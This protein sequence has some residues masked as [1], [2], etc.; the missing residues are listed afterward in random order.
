MLPASYCYGLGAYARLV[1]YTLGLASRRR[2]PAPVISVGNL[3][4]GGTGKT[5]FTIEL[6]ERISSAGK[7]VAV[8]SRGYGR[9]SS[10]EAVVVADGTGA[11]LVPVADS[12]DEPYLIA[13][14]VPDAVVIVGA[15]RLQSA[16]KA[17]VD[18]GAQVLILDDGFQHIKLRRDIDIVLWDYQDDPDGALLLP[19][20]RLREPLSGLNRATDIIVTKIPEDYDQAKLSALVARLSCLAPQ[21]NVASCRF[22]PAYLSGFAFDG[23]PSQ[24][25]K[26][27]ELVGKKVFALSSIARPQ[28]FIAALQGLG[29]NP[30]VEKHFP[31][32]HWFQPQELAQLEQDFLASGADL[33]VTTEKD[34]VRL[35]S[36]LSEPIAQRTWSLVLAAQWLSPVPDIVE[37]LQI[38]QGPL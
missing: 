30:V 38:A 4:V 9:K 13:Q 6:A 11:I 32:H 3:T 23:K 14:A 36:S 21:A 8:L 20:G 2:A 5:P 1:T 22:S 33:L 15:S 12:G 26:L 10:H 35:K 34:M 19:A 37:R 24:P 31:D 29:V 28:S 18:Y 17:V 25:I 27:S 16:R 7:K